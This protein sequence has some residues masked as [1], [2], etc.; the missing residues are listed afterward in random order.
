MEK[1]KEKIDSLHENYEIN[2]EILHKLNDQYNNSLDENLIPKDEET[3]KRIIDAMQKV[4]NQQK[5]HMVEIT[6]LKEELN[7]KKFEKIMAE[8]IEKIDASLE[9]EESTVELP[10]KEDLEDTLDLNELNDIQN[11]KIVFDSQMGVYQIHSSKRTVP[12]LHVVKKELLD[13]NNMKTIK[14]KSRYGNDID[15][16]IVD[17]LDAY[18]KRYNT[19]MKTKYVNNDFD[20][21]IIYDFRKFSSLKKEFLSSK[22]KRTLKKLA[23]NY[24]KN[25]ENCSIINFFNKKA[26]V[27]L[28]IGLT[29]G[30]A[31]SSMSQMKQEDKEYKE[32][33]V[34]V[35]STTLEDLEKT[36]KLPEIITESAEVIVTTE[37]AKEQNNEKKETITEEVK[38]INQEKEEITQIEEKIN[39]KNTKVGDKINLENIDLYYTSLDAEPRGNTMN[40][41]CDEFVVNSISVTY[42][43]EIVQI[44]KDDS[45]SIEELKDKYEKEYG[46]DL[47]ICFNI[48]GVDKNGNVIYKNVGWIDYED[49]MNSQNINTNSNVKLK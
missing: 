16:N 24:S 11:I 34:K 21:K 3:T 26:A 37:E 47:R 10:S 25:H 22:D 17:A 23:K 48:N 8:S 36:E 46:E 13:E 6:K 33:N 28:G 45:S 32:E 49:V 14:E 41:N 1:L 5:N 4:R 30:A 29:A 27:L 15:L 2:R 38:A 18:D 35:E 19:R 40:L 44:V 9:N 42:G 43:S 31:V 39:E 7:K 20:G 12:Y